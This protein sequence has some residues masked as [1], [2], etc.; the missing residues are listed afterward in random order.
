M[1]LSFDRSVP[2]RSEFMLD[3]T[4]FCFFLAFVLVGLFASWA[5]IFFFWF[6][7]WP[8]CLVGILPLG[9]FFFLILTG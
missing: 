3:K 1:Q 7:F 2:H 5:F 9:P 6:F 4:M 8:S